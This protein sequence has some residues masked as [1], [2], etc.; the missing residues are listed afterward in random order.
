M[1]KV[2]PALKNLVAGLTEE[3]K[4]S[5]KKTVIFCRKYTECSS[6]CVAFCNAL[7]PEFTDP[8]GYPDLQEFRRVEIYT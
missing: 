1:V 3:L 6:M 4:V 5:G 2:Q 7:G 8:A